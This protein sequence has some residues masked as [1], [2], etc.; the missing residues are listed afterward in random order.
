MSKTAA[1]HIY[2][3]GTLPLADLDGL[4]RNPYAT[5]SYG[6]PMVLYFGTQIAALRKQMDLIR[7]RKNVDRVRMLNAPELTS[8]RE[9]AACGLGAAEDLYDAM[10]PGMTNDGTV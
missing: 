8:E 7:A 9:K 1:R 2:R 6:A 10:W 5:T 3:L 4:R